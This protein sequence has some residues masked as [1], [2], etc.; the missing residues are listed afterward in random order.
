MRITVSISIDLIFALQEAVFFRCSLLAA[1]RQ[2]CYL[3]IGWEIL[4]G[5]RK[6]KKKK[7]ILIIL[8]WELSIAS[9]F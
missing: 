7:L 2:F 8:F 9:K 4:P 5:R 1:K 6:R 3:A